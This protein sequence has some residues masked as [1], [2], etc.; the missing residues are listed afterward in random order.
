[1]K[2]NKLLSFL[3]AGCML[4]TGCSGGEDDPESDV[5]TDDNQY[6]E[7]T[8]ADGEVVTGED[9]EP[10]T[11]VIP[12]QPVEKELIVGFIYSG[13]ASGNATADYFEAARGEAERVLGA[14]TYYIED[15]LVS[16][17]EKATAA[18][19]D[20]GCNV[21][22][23]TDA[24]FVNAVADEAKANNKVQFISFGGNNSMGNLAAFQGQLYKPAYVCGFAAAYNSDSNILGVLADPSVISVYPLVDAFALGAKELTELNTDIR[25]NWAWGNKDTEVKEALDDLIAQGCDVI[26]CATYSQFA[27]E[28]CE[29]RGVKVIGMFYNMPEL[30]P[31]QYLTGSFC[32]LNIFLIDVLRTVR[33]DTDPVGVYQGGIDEGAVRVVAISE[34]AKEGTKTLTD[35]LY[36]LCSDN[37]AAVFSGEIKD[38]EGEV[39]VPK[40]K[41]LSLEDIYTIDWLESSFKV[42]KN[43]CQ[44]VTQPVPS[45]LYVHEPVSQA[46]D[47]QTTVGDAE[48]EPEEAPVETAE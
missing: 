21:I 36:E 14:K 31:N 35:K 6:V 45:D 2:K 1:M 42:E 40:G 39:K 41:T 44:P 19:V 12:A 48:N 46:G 7:V 18:L 47:T 37:K 23:S 34:K 4:L 33:Y 10:V 9:G 25:I 17:F 32:N 16:Q 24:R 26:Y 20:K 3:L 30:A 29:T 13:K 11:E 8:D 38:S 22:V 28:Y 27:V 43:F 15:V 5:T